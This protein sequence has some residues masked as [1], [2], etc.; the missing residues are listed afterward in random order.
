MSPAQISAFLFEVRPLIFFF[1]F[2]EVRYD[3]EYRLT[4]VDL[5]QGVQGPHQFQLQTNHFTRYKIQLQSHPGSDIARSTRRPR[6]TML[7]YGSS[8][9]IL[10]LAHV[11]PQ[12]SLNR[13]RLED[14]LNPIGPSFCTDTPLNRIVAILL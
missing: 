2:L 1:S 3:G 8:V 4:P 11:S 12:G 6:I 10:H 13:Y 9:Y 14:V 5:S 7:T